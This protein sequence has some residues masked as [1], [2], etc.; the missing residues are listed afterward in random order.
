MWGCWVGKSNKAVDERDD[1]VCFGVEVAE[2]GAKK[3]SA[4]QPTATSAIRKGVTCTT[5]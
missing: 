1:S 5:A 4:K 2:V 3:L